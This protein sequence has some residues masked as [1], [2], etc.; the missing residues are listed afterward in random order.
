MRVTV[1]AAAKH[2][3]C[4]EYA[5]KTGIKQG[6]FPYVLLGGRYLLE[7]EQIE[8]VLRQEAEENRRKARGARCN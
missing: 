1:S 6:R 2:I 7:V 8:A 5:V 3:G 4:S